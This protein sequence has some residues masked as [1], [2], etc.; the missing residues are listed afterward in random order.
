ML[1]VTVSSPPDSK[2][3]VS[4]RV[5]VTLASAPT[6][7]EDMTRLCAETADGDSGVVGGRLP[8]VALSST[9]EAKRADEWRSW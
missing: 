9:R 6:A 2:P 1:S 7:D 5:S 8:A 3:W 4:A